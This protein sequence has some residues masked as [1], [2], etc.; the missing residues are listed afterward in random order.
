MTP[1]VLVAA[2]CVAFVVA[3]F[4]AIRRA[5]RP[6]GSAQRDLGVVSSR[7]ISDLRRDEPWT[8]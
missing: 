7:W 4:Y 2:A 8:R 1:T 6:S 5:I 3:A